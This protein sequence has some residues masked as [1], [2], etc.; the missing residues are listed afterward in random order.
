MSSILDDFFE[1]I[2]SVEGEILRVLPTSSNPAWDDG[3]YTLNYKVG[4][5]AESAFERSQR[6]I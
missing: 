3:P 5:K 2:A 1:S 6:D 4:F